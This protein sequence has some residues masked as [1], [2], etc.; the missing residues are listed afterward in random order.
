[1]NTTQENGDHQAPGN[2]RNKEK[3]TPLLLL[4][5]Q[6]I[7]AHS[8]ISSFSVVVVAPPHPEAA[9]PQRHVSIVVAIRKDGL[10]P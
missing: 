7:V 8:I 9:S 1:M 3:T 5:V 10:Q 6:S 2:T 4:N